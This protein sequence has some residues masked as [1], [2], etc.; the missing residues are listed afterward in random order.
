MYINGRKITLNELRDIV[1]RLFGSLINDL[2]KTITTDGIEA[3]EKKKSN[4]IDI[5]KQLMQHFITTE[6]YEKCAYIRDLLNKYKPKTTKNVN[7]KKK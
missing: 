4:Q 3:V 2:Y 5:L 7:D 6:E 1:D